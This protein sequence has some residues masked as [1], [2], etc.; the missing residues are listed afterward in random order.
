MK[1]R[2]WWILG[3]AGLGLLW[4]QKPRF[5]YIEKV[6]PFTKMDYAHRGLFNQTFPENSK[7]AF[8]RA[9]VEG[10][11]I[12]MDVRRCKD[13]LV[14]HHDEDL[15]RS[16][17]REEKISELSL[18]ELREIKIFESEE[19]IPSLEEALEI[20]GEHVPLLLEIKCEEE[21]FAT[22]KAVQDVMDGFQGDYL[23]ESFQPQVLLW[24][25]IH[26]PKLLRGQLS[27]KNVG[28]CCLRRKVM[29]WLL[30]HVVSRPDFIAFE[31]GGSFWVRLWHG[32]GIPTFVYTL[33]HPD[34]KK[35]YF[36]A[37]IFEGYYSM[38]RILG[39]KQ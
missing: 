14:I 35:N 30:V 20:I 22:A 5:R 34:E 6:K 4:L 27:E 23:I 3:G 25:R 7:G 13:G 31:K 38:R 16:A 8:Q 29:S 2:G 9:V 32:L 12:E 19:T 33:R 1:K 36:D 21:H 18:A 11:G 15:K 26:R 24:Y 39:S 37:G 28:G 17:G 10:Y